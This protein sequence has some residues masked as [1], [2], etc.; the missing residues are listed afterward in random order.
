M[1]SKLTKYSIG[2]LFLVLGVQSQSYAQWIKGFN[3]RGSSGYVTDG[4]NETYWIST[5][6]YPTTRNGV[7]FGITSSTTGT[8]FLDRNNAVDRRWAGMAH[9]NADTDTLGITLRVDLPATGDY[10]VRWA[11]GGDSGYNSRVSKVQLCDNTSCDSIISNIESAATDIWDAT[12]TKLTFS[13]WSAS[14]TSVTKTFSTTTLIIKLSYVYN[15]ETAFNHLYIEQSSALAPLT[16]PTLSTPS[17]SATGVS[18]SVSLEWGDTNSS[19]NE[20]NYSCKIKATGGSY[21]SYYDSA[22]NSTSVSAATVLGSGLSTSTSY[23]WTCK[24]K[25][26]GSTTSDSADAT[27]RSFT[28]A[29]AAAATRR[30]I[31]GGGVF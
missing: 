26:D 18:T 4:T 25:G 20:T 30:R 16:A 29:A 8:S 15:T 5:D 1:Y 21:G 10:I 17:D 28:T 31:I 3:F 7:T 19:P 23:T 13:T 12:G 6:T 9:V 27:E 14:N 24:A 11:Q 2:L 22:A